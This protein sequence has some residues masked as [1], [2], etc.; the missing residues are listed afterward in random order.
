MS[1]I[2]INPI[3]AHVFNQKK[4]ESSETLPGTSSHTPGRA[5]SYKAPPRMN[6]S[7]LVW[8]AYIEIGFVCQ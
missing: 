1:L 5:A 4:K 6:S 7:E 3:N 8:Q 2:E